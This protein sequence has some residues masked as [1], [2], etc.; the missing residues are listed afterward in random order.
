MANQHSAKEQAANIL[1]YGKP[2]RLAQPV[3]LRAGKFSLCYMDG[4]LRYIKVG[5]QEVLRMI[6]HAVRDS[7]WGTVPLQLFN[8]TIQISENSFKINYQAEARQ[9]DVAYHWNC[10]II[11]T[12][13]TMLHFSIN[14]EAL[15]NFKRNRM[16]FTVLHPIRECAGM[17]VRISH[18][19][20][21]YTE[22]RF[23]KLISPHQPF[24]DIQAMEWPLGRSGQVRLTFSGDIFEMEDQRNWI[25]DSFKTYCT[26]LDL[27]FPV[28]IALGERVQQS[29]QLEYQ[30]EENSTETVTN[31]EIPSFHLAPKAC[32][33]PQIGIGQSSE[34]RGFTAIAEKYFAQ[35]P[36]DYYQVDW[37]LNEANWIEHAN[38]GIAEAKALNYKLALNLFFF[39]PAR[40]LNGLLAFLQEKISSVNIGLINVF[41]GRAVAS[42]AT[43][44][45]RVI[46]KLKEFAPHIPIGAG[47]NAFF[48]ELNRN[49]PPLENLDHLVYSINPQVHAF[50]NRSL[51]E[52]LNAIPY[53]VETTR[54]FA[55]GKA[56][57]IGPI[58]FKMRWNPNATGKIAPIPGQLPDQVDVRQMSLFGAGWL[59]GCINSLLKSGVKVATFFETIGLQ[60]IIQSSNPKFPDQFRAPAEVVYPLFFAF[61]MLLEQKDSDFFP[62]FPSDALMFS[63]IAFKNKNQT[64][65]DLVLVN[66]RNDSISIQLPE[67]FIN[68]SGYLITTENIESLMQHPENWE[69]LKKLNFPSTIELPRYGIL[70]LK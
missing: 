45:E 37:H 14:G 5:D 58:T 65:R 2:E 8:E 69:D 70:L 67:M 31:Q 20:G 61:R 16:G 3:I 29:I 19:N 64:T 50:D 35:I 39:D 68:R 54:A 15:S 36:F 60:G 42:Q 44:L 27:P 40:E 43:T 46:P 18:P 11:G 6:N 28:N 1:A 25:D 26:P 12:E 63:G 38:Q 41:D 22:N 34:V 55:P 66:F 49:R 33:L 30:E 52:T 47:T 10:E 48:T 59:L 24:K 56:I 57:H 9:G 62:I 51:T 17:P 7:N 21:T 4:F 23:P 13:N 53:T 32:S